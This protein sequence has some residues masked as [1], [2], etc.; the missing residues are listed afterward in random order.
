[1]VAMLVGWTPGCDACKLR[2]DAVTFD[3]FVEERRQ[4]GFAGTIRRAGAN[5]GGRQ[6]VHPVG[7]R[8]ASGGAR[9]QG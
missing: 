6:S 8:L 7:G 3:V 4:R 5:R 9:G 1:M 2:Q